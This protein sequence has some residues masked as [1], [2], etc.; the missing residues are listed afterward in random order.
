MND[1]ISKINLSSNAIFIYIF[2]KPKKFKTKV[3]IKNKFFKLLWNKNNL[4]KHIDI[5]GGGSIIV[6][7]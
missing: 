1:K 3:N 2:I 7:L 4:Q 6:T 5:T